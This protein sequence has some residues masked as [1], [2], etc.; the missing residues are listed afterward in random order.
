VAVHPLLEELGIRI[1]STLSGDG[2]VERIR[3]APRQPQR[4][5]LRQVPGDP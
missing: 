4:A 1:L 2:R 5:G 3:T